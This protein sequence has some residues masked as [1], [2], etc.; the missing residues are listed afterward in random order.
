M[1]FL[2]FSILILIIILV[3]IYL[4]AIKTLRLEISK[5]NECHKK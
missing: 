1:V 2:I 4:N 3:L 5:T